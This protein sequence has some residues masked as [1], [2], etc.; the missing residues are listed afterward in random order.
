MS[1]LKLPSLE[2]LGLLYVEF[3]TEP[4]EWT[5]FPSLRHLLFNGDDGLLDALS[6]LLPQLDTLT[7]MSDDFDE[8]RFT[9]TLSFPSEKILI[10]HPWTWPD[11]DLLGAEDSLVHFRLLVNDIWDSGTLPDGP[12]ADAFTS[13]LTSKNR[14]PRL[15]TIYLPPAGSL[16]E[17]Y[18]EDK[19]GI[20][21][22][23]ERLAYACQKRNVEV[24][25]EEQSDKL[26]SECQVSE[27]FMRRMTQRRIEREAEGEGG[28]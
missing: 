22:A 16:P 17:Y 4:V 6:N 20:S 8:A 7:I 13:L 9:Q 19:E 11:E 12:M 3:E 24:V 5:I 2:V 14:F 18:D 10:N 21:A 27:E 23:L 25:F 26:G 1:N 28:K 15:N